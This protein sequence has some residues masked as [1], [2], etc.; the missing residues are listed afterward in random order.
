MFVTDGVA[1]LALP[2]RA[3]TLSVFEAVDNV[4]ITAF[5]VRACPR[6]RAASRRTSRSTNAAPGGKRVQVQVAG[7]GAAPTLRA[8]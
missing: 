5:E 1:R 8:Q 2:A 6:S 3:R 7:V 4:G